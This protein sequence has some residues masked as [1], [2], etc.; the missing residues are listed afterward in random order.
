VPI[1]RRQ[2]H[3]DPAEKLVAASEAAQLTV[4]GSHGM[5]GFAGMLLG[6]VS[7]AV[8]QAARMPVIVARQ[9]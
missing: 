9:S 3:G 2:V 4:V 5:G 8:V 1:D 6:S 7:S